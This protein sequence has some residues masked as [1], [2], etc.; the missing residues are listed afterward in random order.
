MLLISL[1]YR[2]LRYLFYKHTTRK[3]C[4]VAL[5]QSRLILLQQQEKYKRAIPCKR[6]CSPPRWP[7]SYFRG[8]ACPSYGSSTKWIAIG[9]M[10]DAGTI[11]QTGSLSRPL[12]QRKYCLQYSTRPRV[13]HIHESQVSARKHSWLNTLS[14]KPLPPLASIVLQ[15]R[16]KMR[17]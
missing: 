4:S 17:R 9:Y 15:V 2:L 11:C 14:E 12:S 3:D 5:V 7:L 6:H 1:K 10:S 16:T 13:K 8:P